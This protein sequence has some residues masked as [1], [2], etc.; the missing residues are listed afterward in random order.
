MRLFVSIAALSNLFGEV[1]GFDH[2]DLNRLCLHIL[3]EPRP[4][5]TAGALV[6]L[7]GGM[8]VEKVLDGGLDAAWRLAAA[9]NLDIT[10]A[11]EAVV[12][13]V[14]TFALTSEQFSSIP[15][16]IASVHRWI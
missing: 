9:G 12:M 2:P 16:Y 5:S 7:K 1:I 14:N 8:T 6:L 15:Q 10:N 3:R 4:Q 13:T 11:A